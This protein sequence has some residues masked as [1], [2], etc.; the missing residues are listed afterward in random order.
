[1]AGRDSYATRIRP[2]LATISKWCGQ[3]A[4]DVEI[5]SKLGISRVTLA[6]HRQ[7]HPEL[8]EAMEAAKERA[9]MKVEAGLFKR[10]CGYEYD[11]IT[12]KPAIDVIAKKLLKHAEAQGVKLS[13]KE[14]QEAFGSTRVEV[15]RVKR[16]VPPDTGAAM[17]WLTNRRRED[18]KHR[19][20]QTIRVHDEAAILLD[21]AEKKLEE[22]LA[23]EGKRGRVLSMVTSPVEKEG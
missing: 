11:E 15:C 12:L 7:I 18:W 4:T 13:L 9:D 3:G 17:A 14:L 20:E 1:M 16:N 23:K 2:H 5:S 6:K 19:H 21:N 8:L 10:A 22:V